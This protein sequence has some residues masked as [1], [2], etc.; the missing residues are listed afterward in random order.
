MF[1]SNDATLGDSEAEFTGVL[2]VAFK[3]FSSDEFLRP[4][5]LFEALARQSE[6]YDPET[7]PGVRWIVDRALEAIERHQLV[8]SQSSDNA[9]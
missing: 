4:E 9:R 6:A 1:G 8:A 5:S 2:G 7:M 3:L